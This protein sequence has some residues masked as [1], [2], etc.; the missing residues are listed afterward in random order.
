M[1]SALSPVHRIPTDREL[2]GRASELEAIGHAL[3]YVAAGESWSVALVGEPGIGKTAL[4]DAA[5]ELSEVAGLTVL[6]GRGTEFESEVP[7]GM[8]VDALDTALATDRDLLSHL[9]RDRLEE[10]ARV[11][12][13][14][15]SGAHME[16]PGL[17][18]E[19]FRLYL[20]VRH[21]LEEL[22]GQGPL[23]LALDDAHWADPASVELLA[24]LLRHSVAGPL[25]FLFTYRPHQT[26]ELLLHATAAAT[27]EGRASTLEL[28][29]LTPEEADEL[30]DDRLDGSARSAIYEQTGG[31]PFYLTELARLDDVDAYLL[32]EGPQLDAADP[33]R[34]PPSV[35]AAMAHEVNAVSPDARA[36][37]EAAAVVGE[38]FELELAAGVARLDEAIAIEALNELGNEDLIRATDTPGRYAFRHPILRR[39]VYESAETGFTLSAHRRAAE[40]LEQW[41]ASPVARAGHVERSARMGDLEAI[42]VLTAAADQAAL[43]APL[44]AARWLA[45]ALRLLPADAPPCRRLELLIPL[46]TAL[47]TSGQ[48][49]EARARL[50]EALPLLPVDEVVLKARLVGAMA[51]LDHMAGRH[52]GARELLQRALTEVGEGPSAGSTALK[53]ELAMDHWLAD[54]WEQTVAIAEQTRADARVLD[55]ALSYA[56]ATGLEAVG[57]GYLGQLE[58]AAALADEAAGIVDGLPDS[59][60]AARVEALVIISHAEFG[61]IERAADSARHANR[62]IAISRATGQDSWYVMLQSERC[63]ANLLLG[64]LAEASEAADLALESGRLGHF[65]PQIWALTLRCWV[66]LLK[67]DL[68]RAIAHGE[69]ATAIV[70]RTGTGLFNWVAYACLA[71]AMVDAGQPTRARDLI[72]DHAG[73][74]DLELVERGWLAHW[75]ETLTLAAL[76]AGDVDAAR[77]WADRCQAAAE[78]FP[79]PGRLAE[80][81]YARAALA[82]YRGQGAQAVELSVAAAEGFTAADWPIDTARARILAARGLRSLGQR[83]RAIPLLRRSYAE[84]DACGARGYRD[85]AARELQLLGDRP[86]PKR[87]LGAAQRVSFERLSPREREVAELVARGMTNRQ[88][89]DKLFVSPKT[90]ESHMTRILDKAG[91]PNRAA[92]AAAVE[93]WHSERR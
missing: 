78:A 88:V 6:R 64:R 75:Y 27:R 14:L 53:L 22:V 17:R 46:A 82:L 57:R 72:L 76:G 25:L 66:D 34:V 12:P 41:G 32:S 39:A 48:V 7:L 52:G 3:R 89:A 90:V 26:P 86:P 59:E 74:P 56:T 9:G 19:R 47:G 91:V 43:T 15:S 1:G 65:Q 24:Y 84:L 5:C 4:L 73:G 70:E 23:V 36:L 42:A 44:N 54:D 50:A 83:T 18:V 93:R 62:G 37:L 85:E 38:P 29:P 20:A 61:G 8:F 87:G 81:R 71:M 69:E 67:G 35:R 13:S 11:F 58:R 30:L 92:L 63:V 45:G 80:A 79:T 33:G 60:L 16:T 55:D 49:E 68:S 28:D 51:R 10:L 2:V 40:L 31:N 77:D 21:A